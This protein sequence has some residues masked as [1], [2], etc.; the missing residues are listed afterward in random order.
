MPRRQRVLLDVDGVLADFV[1]P[2]LQVVEQ[3]TGA[4]PPVD[5]TE[6]WDL[7][8]AYDKKTQSKFYDVFKTEGWCRALQPY[9]GASEFI[10]QLERIADVYFVTSPMH[11]PHWAHE[12]NLWLLENFDVPSKRVVSTNAKYLCVGDVFVDDKFSHVQTW[13]AAHPHGCAVVWSQPYNVN[14]VW[15][16]RASSYDDII[17]LVTL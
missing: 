2:A 13:K 17:Q 3:I 11:G 4:P 12:R 6:D 1:T 10:G 5:A 7:F 15:A 9:P 16:H 14:E 8:R